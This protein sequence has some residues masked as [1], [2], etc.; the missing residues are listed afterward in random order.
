MKKLKFIFLALLL[1]GP[2]SAAA[3]G[4]RGSGPGS[5]GREGGGGQVLAGF[6][7][8][9]GRQLVATLEQNPRPEPDPFAG[10]AI[11][12][13]LP[14]LRDAVG[15]VNLWILPTLCRVSIRPDGGTYSYCPDAEYDANLD[16]IRISE[17]VINSQ[18]CIDLAFLLAH[19]YGR[20]AGIEGGSYHFSVRYRRDEQTRALCE[21]LD[22]NRG[23]RRLR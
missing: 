15:R 18:R 7:A 19:E 6:L 2:L 12:E 23:F 5:G 21:A 17:T 20:A 14:K 8:E 3:Q 10:L 4:A 13:V 22:N 1:V 16:L 11:A 9:I